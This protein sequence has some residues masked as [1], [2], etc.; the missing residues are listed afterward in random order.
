MHKPITGLR[1]LGRVLLPCAF[2]A[3]ILLSLTFS[4]SAFAAQR[5]PSATTQH[6]A[7]AI[8][9]SPSCGNEWRGI[10]RV[11]KSV[12]YYGTYVSCTGGVPISLSAKLIVQVQQGNSW[13]ADAAR[14]GSCNDCATLRVPKGVGSYTYTG[15]PGQ[16]V[17]IQISFS[18][19]LANSKYGEAG[20][21]GPYTFS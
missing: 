1:H 15:T 5:S 10:V 17:R 18:A 12:L 13:I 19:V 4:Q 11:S 8:P 9:M 20:T 2:I 21:A 3:A 6:S 14:T 7:P 16:K